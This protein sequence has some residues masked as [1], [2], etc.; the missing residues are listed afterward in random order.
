MERCLTA[1]GGLLRMETSV[2]VPMVLPKTFY[3]PALPAEPVSAAPEVW[4]LSQGAATLRLAAWGLGAAIL[5]TNRF[6][7]YRRFRKRLERQGGSEPEGRTRL[8]LLSCQQQVG[9]TGSVRL[10]IRTAAPTPFVMILRKEPV[11][12]AAYGTRSERGCIRISD[13]RFEAPTD[14]AACPHVWE[15]PLYDQEGNV[16][17]TYEIGCG[18]HRDFSGM[19]VKEGKMALEAARTTA[20]REARA[21][22]Q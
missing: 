15:L 3:R 17:G 16:I 20:V 13:I 22:N 6:A 12:A 11:Y 4:S 5:L 7:A 21:Q 19:T 18:G 9:V 14:A 8:M 2:N 10:H 1:L